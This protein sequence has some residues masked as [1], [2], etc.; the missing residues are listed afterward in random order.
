MITLR[1]RLAGLA[2]C[3]CVAIIVLGVPVLLTGI[4]ATPTLADVAWERL[5]APDDGTLAMVVISVVAWIA[6]AVMTVSILAE[7]T[8]RVRRLPTI[9][10]PGLAIPQRAASQLVAAAAMLFIATPAVLPT[11]MVPA[12]RAAPT[13]ATSHAAETTSATQ[14]PAQSTIQSPAQVGAPATAH[15]APRTKTVPY[16]VQR[17]D[18]LWKIAERHL[19]DGARF[20]EIVDLNHDLLNGHPDFITAGL[21]LRLPDVRHTDAAT[22]DASANSSAGTTAADTYLV[23]RGDTLSGI[24]GEELGDAHAYPALYDANRGTQQ[25]DGSALEDPD[26]ILPGW[27]LRIPRPAT[28]TPGSSD[29][30]GSSDSPDATSQPL[31]DNRTDSPSRPHDLPPH[32]LD[33]GLDHGPENGLDQEPIA[34]PSSEHSA[35]QEATNADPRED[36]T[37]DTTTDNGDTEL[38]A[39]IMVGLTGAGAALAG[40]LLIAIRQ[41]RRTQLRYRTPGHLVRP[42]PDALTH[43][44]KSAHA[45][46]S[47]TA[48]RIAEL[49]RALRGLNTI[50]PTPRLA[51]VALTHERISLSLAEPATLPAPW[52]GHGTAWVQALSPQRPATP[53]NQPRGNLQDDPQ[54]EGDDRESASGVAPYP[55]LVSVG[56]GDDGSLVLVNL[57]E[58]RAVTLTGDPELR[59]SLARHLAAELALNPWA[60][61]VDIETVGIGAELEAIDQLRMHQ[62]R[63][64]DTIALTQLVASLAEEDADVEPDQFRCVIGGVDTA[65]TDVFAELADAVAQYPSRPAAAVVAIQAKAL[66]ASTEMHLTSDG[67]LH[68]TTLDLDL[69]ASGLTADEAQACAD[70]VQVITDTRDEPL[71]PFPPLDETWNAAGE[72]APELT[73]PRPAADP[74]GNTSVLPELTKSYEQTAATRAED[75]DRLAPGVPPG[76]AAE[77]DAA[78]PDLYDDLATWESPVLVAPKL[79]LLGPVKARTPGDPKK[80]AN[81]RAFYVELL[82]YLT[83][84]PRGVTAEVVADAFGLRVERARIDLSTLRSWL[85]IN[86][87]TGEPYLPNARQTHTP[88]VAATYRVDGVLSD[89]DL[90]RRLRRRGQSRGATGIDDLVTALGLVSGEPFTELRDTG[91]TWLLDGD[92]IDHVMTAAIVDT[93]HL[94]TAH[95]LSNDDLDLAAFSAKTAYTAA[96]YDEIAR[97]DLIAVDHALGNHDDADDALRNEV[98]NRSDDDLGPVDLPPRTAEIIRQRGWQ[99]IRNRSAG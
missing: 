14:S 85:G 26:L 43:V 63:A 22:A 39:W 8:A 11:P 46:G 83:L 12:A 84:H 58:L 40:S 9:H 68:I 70:L 37:T 5:T 10:F 79:T 81:R 30:T 76:A 44:E 74:V 91:W 67:R 62:R 60:T 18:S 99:P 54:D 95:A 29:T 52:H 1:A 96:P 89:L 45:A 93:A 88:G 78:D 57:E 61:L 80:G 65:N 90:F 64:D 56:Q 38:P 4:H 2:A 73:H 55:L 51:Q 98:V 6:W 20:R 66:E 53:G 47:L 35:G 82:A 86:P 94:V 42:T 87:Q 92:R 69:R 27:R 25:A 36:I 19:G 48:P 16:T 13:N 34:D 32:G 49:D 59:L 31:G 33:H 41:R 97:L 23:Q 71:A 7:V 3:F 28:G 17:G 72:L 75:I 24:A 15:S 77:V 21:Q 50:Q